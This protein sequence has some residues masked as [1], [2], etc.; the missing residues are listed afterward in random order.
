MFDEWKLP[1]AT[2]RLV[3]TKWGWASRVRIGLVRYGD[4]HTWELLREAVKR[5]DG[6]VAPPEASQSTL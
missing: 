2:F 6:R 5:L 1:L 3:C 4:K